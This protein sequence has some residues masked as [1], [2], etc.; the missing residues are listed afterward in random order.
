MSGHIDFEI[1]EKLKQ[2]GLSRIALEDKNTLLI[3]FEK[4]PYRFTVYNTINETIKPI[5][6]RLKQYINDNLILQQIYL[7]ISR[8]WNKINNHLDYE[9]NNIDDGSIRR[10]EN[11]PVLNTT[12]DQWIEIL[13]EKHSSLFKLVSDTFPELVQP[14]EFALS[15]KSILNIK[16]C[17][18]PFGGIILG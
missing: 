10:E 18:L 13:R 11:K 17:S 5:E 8:N 12:N 14:L 15:V 2:S 6:R 1:N 7:I 9:D 16:D 4:I 3:E